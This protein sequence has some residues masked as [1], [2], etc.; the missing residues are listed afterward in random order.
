MLVAWFDNRQARPDNKAAIAQPP[1]RPEHVEGLSFFC[2]RFKGEGRGFDKLSPNGVGRRTTIP[3]D[4]QAVQPHQLRNP[5]AAIL[6][7]LRRT[8]RYNQTHFLIAGDPQLNK[9]ITKRPV[10]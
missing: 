3:H 1:V 5:K 10:L 8:R 7:F 9:I 6:G 4:L 2:P